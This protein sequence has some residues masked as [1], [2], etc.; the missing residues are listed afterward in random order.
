MKKFSKTTLGLI[1]L[2]VGT[3]ISFGGALGSTLAWYTYS[4]TVNVQFKGTSILETEQLQVGIKTDITFPAEIGDPYGLTQVEAENGDIYTFAAPGMGFDS[5]LIQYYLSQTEYSISSLCPITSKKYDTGD[6][7]ELYV[8]PRAGD[9]NS[10]EHPKKDHY[11][12][13][14]FAFRVVKIDTASV[15]TYVPNQAIW[16]S[17]ARAVADGAGE[18]YKAVRVFISGSKFDDDENIVANKFIFN[19]S[20]SSTSQKYTNVAGLLNLDTDEYYDTFTGIYE[21]PREVIYG[22]YDGEVTPHYIEED[23]E[24]D[25]I[26]NT[27]NSSLATTFTAKHQAGTIAYSSLSGIT[28]HKANFK[29]LSDIR[30]DVNEQGDLINGEVVA[31]TSNSDDAIADLETT[32]YLEG[33]DHSVINQELFHRFFLGMTFEIN[34]VA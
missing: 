14:P 18:I 29:S 5:S 16:I 24:L 20:A 15:D 1:A 3:V 12:K 13:I 21:Y 28:P 2:S 7:L 4:T 30:P 31:V 19:P 33:W 10:S 6:D 9:P 25:D 32:I 23:S 11:V 8:P 26:N 34:K 17:N 22:E 27:G